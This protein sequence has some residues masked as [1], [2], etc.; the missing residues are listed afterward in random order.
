MI[1]KDLLEKN[2]IEVLIDNNVDVNKEYLSK[3]DFDELLKNIF[4]VSFESLDQAE[5][6]NDAIK[7]SIEYKNCLQNKKYNLYEIFDSYH[8]E[9]LKKYKIEIK[10]IDINEQEYKEFLSSTNKMSSE[11]MEKI[12]DYLDDYF[13]GKE[14][15]KQCDEFKTPLGNF[16]LVDK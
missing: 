14:E 10:N 6:I 15:Y 1:L 8:K 13:K 2:D 4:R 7:D 12:Y 11:D 9:L 3:E 5:R 16:K